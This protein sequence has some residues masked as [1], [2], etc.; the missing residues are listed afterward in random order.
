MTHSVH[1]IIMHWIP[2]PSIFKWL[3]KRMGWWLK[4]KGFIFDS[5]WSFQI[6]P[7]TVIFSKHW[8]KQKYSK[9]YVTCLWAIK[10]LQSV[11]WHSPFTIHHQKLS[12][13][14]K[15]TIGNIVI[16]RDLSRGL[17]CCTAMSLFYF[18]TQTLQFLS[19]KIY[20]ILFTLW[21]WTKELRLPTVRKIWLQALEN[22]EN[23]RRLLCLI[24]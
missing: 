19:C 11:A 10:G 18:T 5:V 20:I 4:W 7:N 8:H 22:D 6:D 15:G 1:S 21:D 17:T 24:F 14:L 13:T 9:F 23:L 2:C 3:Y 12:D 16:L